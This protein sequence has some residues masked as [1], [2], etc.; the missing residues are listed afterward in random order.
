M[1]AVEKTEW[2]IEIGGASV[3]TLIAYTEEDTRTLIDDSIRRLTSDW[4]PKRGS[5]RFEVWVRK[6]IRFEVAIDPVSEKPA[7]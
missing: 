6:V 7:Q 1:K 4:D 3:P 5:T 2:Q